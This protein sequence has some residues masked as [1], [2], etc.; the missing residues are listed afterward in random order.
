MH[1]L[2]CDNNIKYLLIIKIF[3]QSVLLSNYIFINTSFYFVLIGANQ[4]KFNYF[5]KIKK[6]PFL[7]Q[8]WNS[9]ANLFMDDSLFI[10]QRQK[11]FIYVN[12]NNNSNNNSNNNNNSSNNSNN[13]SNSNNNNNNS[14]GLEKEKL[15][16]VTIY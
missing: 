2:T 16:S 6:D 11:T 7:R 14:V 3:Y 12:N 10:T 8:T 15:C 1:T 9:S 4:S 5:L 13:N